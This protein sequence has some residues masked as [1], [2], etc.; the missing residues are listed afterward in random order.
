LKPSTSC[1]N[2]RGQAGSISSHDHKISDG[3][4]I[5]EMRFQAIEQAVRAIGKPQ[6][7]IK[8]ATPSRGASR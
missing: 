8:Q 2:R 7:A 1:A 4:I 3:D 5:A 6:R